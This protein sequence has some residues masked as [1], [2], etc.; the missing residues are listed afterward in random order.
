LTV[1][2]PT[3]CRIVFFML[4]AVVFHGIIVVSLPCTICFHSILPEL[5]GDLFGLVPAIVV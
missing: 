3:V 4:Q 1:L 2:L 5:I